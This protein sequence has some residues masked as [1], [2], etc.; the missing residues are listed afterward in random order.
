MTRAV[1]AFAAVSPWQRFVDWNA[2]YCFIGVN[3]RV[4]TMV[5][6]VET[7]LVELALARAPQK[8]RSELAAAV[9]GWMKP[10]VW[11]SFRVTIARP[12]SGH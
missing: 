5:H 9:E 4:N 6:Y 11:P 10:G 7:L 12:S 2:A 1:V 8:R 3:F